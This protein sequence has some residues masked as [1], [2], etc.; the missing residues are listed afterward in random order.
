MSRKY[1]QI[2]N[3]Q[4]V[5]HANGEIE[6]SHKC[7]YVYRYY[8]DTYINDLLFKKGWLVFLL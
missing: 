2:H 4:P 5:T 3:N 7:K 1:I 6:N 8:E